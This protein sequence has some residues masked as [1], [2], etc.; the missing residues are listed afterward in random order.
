MNDV[1]HALSQS[2]LNTLTY[3]AT[4]RSNFLARPIVAVVDSRLRHLVSAENIDNMKIK[5]DEKYHWLAGTEV[6]EV[7]ERVGSMWLVKAG[8]FIL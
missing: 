4:K 8:I 3:F 6:T 5:Y 7:Q 1:K 2:R